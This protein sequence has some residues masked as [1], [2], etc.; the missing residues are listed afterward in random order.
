MSVFGIHYLLPAK[1][2]E[3]EPPNLFYSYHIIT[4]FRKNVYTLTYFS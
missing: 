2:S 4:H 3:L 1:D